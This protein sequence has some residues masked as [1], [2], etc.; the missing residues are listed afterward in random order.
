[1]IKI[2]LF[3]DIIV[4]FDSFDEK[5]LLR[6]NFNKNFNLYL[7][8]NQSYLILCMLFYIIDECLIEVQGVDLYLY[9]VFLW[10]YI[11]YFFYSLVIKC[12]FYIFIE[13]EY[14]EVI[15]QSVLELQEGLVVG[16]VICSLL[17]LIFICKIIVDFFRLFVDGESEFK[18]NVQY[19]ILYDIF[20]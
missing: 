18:L 14:Y 11:F 13:F 7:E 19:N 16:I 2:D 20:V 15:V 10:L 9:V 17:K 12:F 5:D 4:K 3:K 6:L 8:K 1:M